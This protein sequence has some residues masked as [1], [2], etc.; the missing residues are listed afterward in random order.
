MQKLE[1]TFLCYVTQIS[2]ST[3][4]QF[5]TAINYKTKSTNKKTSKLIDSEKPHLHETVI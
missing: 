3:F 5:W 4:L 2:E 1:L